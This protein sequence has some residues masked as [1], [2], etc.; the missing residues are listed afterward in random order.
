MRGCNNQNNRSL[1]SSGWP[2]QGGHSHCGCK[3]HDSLAEA[4]DLRCDIIVISG[5]NY[6]SD[7]VNGFLPQKAHD[8]VEVDCGQDL[9]HNEVSRQS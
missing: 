7:V 3:T 1:Q 9:T 5:G 4:T 2:P 8:S 6:V